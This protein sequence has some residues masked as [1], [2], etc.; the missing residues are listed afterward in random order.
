[1]GFVGFNCSLLHKVSVIDHLDG[2]GESARIMGAV[3]CVV[4]RDEQWIGEN[5]DGK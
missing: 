3:N 1:M 4:Q 2:L 5:T